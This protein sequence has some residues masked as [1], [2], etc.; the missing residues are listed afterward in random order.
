MAN[1]TGTNN[2]SVLITNKRGKGSYRVY[3]AKP[4][5][6]PKGKKWKKPFTTDQDQQDSANQ[7]HLTLKQ[8]LIKLQDVQQVKS[9]ARKTALLK[10]Y[11]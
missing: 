10:T 11:T 5:K 8:K 7:N 6:M 9:S 1:E 2:L 4:L 3:K